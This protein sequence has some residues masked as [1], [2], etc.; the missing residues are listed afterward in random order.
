MQQGRALSFVPFPSQFA[1]NQ[2][3]PI[4]N[5]MYRARSWSAHIWMLLDDFVA[6]L[7]SPPVRKFLL[8]VQNQHFDLNWQFVG[9]AIWS[10]FLLDKRLL[11]KLKVFLPDLVSSFSGNI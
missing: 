1:L 9:V 11:S 5:G 4:Q 8:Q 6:N 2:T 3:M 7:G 10:S